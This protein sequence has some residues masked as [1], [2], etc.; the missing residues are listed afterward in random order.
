MNQHTPSNHICDF[1]QER[2]DSFQTIAPLKII[3][4]SLA[5]RQTVSWDR[6][7]CE[8]EFPGF[9]GLTTKANNTIHLQTAS[10]S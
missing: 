6:N 10:F 5:E 3:N 9:I 1:G 8:A 7:D 4:V 2:Q